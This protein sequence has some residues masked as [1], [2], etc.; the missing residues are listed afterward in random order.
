MACGGTAPAVV[1]NPGGAPLQGTGKQW[2]DEIQKGSFEFFW[3]ETNPLTGQV[4]DR[5]FLNG[6]HA[7]DGEHRRDRVWLDVA[8]HR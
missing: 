7:Q 2:L 4:K 5:A 3:N 1:Q 6:K 8:V